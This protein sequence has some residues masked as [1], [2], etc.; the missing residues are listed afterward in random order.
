[1]RQAQKGK[2]IETCDTAAIK[3]WN[4]CLVIKF[5][6]LDAFERLSKTV[7]FPKNDKTKI[8]RSKILEFLPV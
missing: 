5:E 2:S 1:M 4:T 8:D 7:S 3:Q 6:M